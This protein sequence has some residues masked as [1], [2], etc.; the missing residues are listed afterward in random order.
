[1]DGKA[2]A[3][4]IEVEERIFMLEEWG[5]DIIMVVSKMLRWF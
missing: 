4:R 1:M 2:M 3:A 5:W